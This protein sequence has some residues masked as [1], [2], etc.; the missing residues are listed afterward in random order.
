ML[1]NDGTV[2]ENL[3]RGEE[4][5]IDDGKSIF[6]DDKIKLTMLQTLDS[7][8]ICSLPSNPAIPPDHAHIPP[9]PPHHNLF[10]II[11]IYL[12]LSWRK[13]SKNSVLNISF[14]L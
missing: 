2:A 14:G 4:E 10:R 1:G 11:I 7:I 5:I 6:M 3:G 8:K 13:W 9:S 12:C